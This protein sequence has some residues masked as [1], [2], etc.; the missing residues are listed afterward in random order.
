VFREA[1]VNE[2][3][4]NSALGFEQGPIRPPSEAG[5]LLIR[6][7][8]NCPW[9]RC[10]FCHTYRGE[11]YSRRSAE[12]VRGDIRTARAVA[13][14]LQSLSMRAG[15]G[16]EIGERTIAA[17][18]RNPALTQAH[19]SVANFLYNGG[20]TAFLQD[21]DPLAGPLA[22]T[23]E[24]LRALREAFPS[25]ERVTTYARSRTAARIGPAGF[26][27]LREAGL[28]R[29]HIGMESGSDAVL[30][31]IRKGVD[32]ETHVK[33]GRAVKE[34]GLELSEYVMPG[35]GGR[36]FTEEH[37]RESAS[38]LN[39]IGPDFVRLRTLAVIATADLEAAVERGEM[40]R[41]GEDDIVR[42]I[43]ALVSALEIPTRLESDH[44][45]NLLEEVQGDLPGD[46]EAILGAIDA[47]LGLPEAER[48]HF[49]I[50]RR[51]CIYR[52]LADMDGPRRARVD[53]IVTAMN[54]ST[55]EDADA[56][57]WEMMKRFV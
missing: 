31:F 48:I 42:E 19:W 47:Y 54:V 22:S 51:A 28:D 24:V 39:R 41:L 50:G 30:E 55:P 46:R 21:A 12:E 45:L 16:G 52:R 40:E 17:L 44:I 7:T 18:Q 5:S 11:R 57:I 20:R 8:R 9:N 56:L 6:L 26:E 2:E 13:E 23:A 25:I 4:R 10:A 33:G 3:E 49:R 53:G 36:R 34:A 14:E 1:N 32:A 29:V 37:A 15:E 38:V 35:V 27:T 43:R